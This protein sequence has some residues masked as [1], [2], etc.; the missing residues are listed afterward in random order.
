MWAEESWLLTVENRG[1][2]AVQRRRSPPDTGAISRLCST[3]ASECVERLRL[4]TSTSC[5]S[6]EQSAAPQFSCEL[7]EMHWWFSRPQLGGTHS[8]HEVN[9]TSDILLRLHGTFTLHKAS[10]G[11][12]IRLG[13]SVEDSQKDL[14]TPDS[15]VTLIVSKQWFHTLT[16]WL[17]VEIQ[18]WYLLLL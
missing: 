3:W 16:H 6:V 10:K 9:Q 1:F 13:F 17:T 8:E 5:L 15:S 4:E 18:W 2:P 11:D 7:M 14:H 12:L